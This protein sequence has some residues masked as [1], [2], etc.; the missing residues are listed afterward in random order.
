MTVLQVNPMLLKMAQS[1]VWGQAAQEKR[2]F[3][4]GPAMDPMAAGGAPP[5]P[6]GAPPMDPMAAGGMP[7]P[8]DPMAAGGMPPPMDPAAAGAA[9]MPPMGDP[10]AMGG[11]PPM[12]PMAAGAAGAAG[13]APKMKPEQMMQMIDFRMYNMQQQI[14][15]MLNALN[16]EIPP[17]ALVTPP[18]QMTPPPEAAMPGG[19]QD[20]SQQAGAEQGGGG[21]GSAISAIEPMQGAS[22]EMAAMGGGG[23]GGGAPKMASALPYQ[24]VRN[25]QY[26]IPEHAQFLK[27]A[28]AN[29]PAGWNVVLEKTADGIANTR[30]TDGNVEEQPGPKQSSPPQK[31]LNVAGA[32]GTRPG[33][34]AITAGGSKDPK[35]RTEAGDSLGPA[36]KAAAFGAALAGGEVGVPV[37][38]DT[39]EPQPGSDSPV[40][41]A[42]A[43]AAMFRSRTQYGD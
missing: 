27:E 15:A 10:M 29:A 6:G 3:Q 38:H 2:A 14:T 39:V 25:P 28:N 1:K 19:Q 24:F 36:N 18:G 32:P 37:P 23:G 26:A 21:G 33:T 8:M 34:Q 12:D 5:P 16:V 13:A 43:L 22:P 11:A 40:Q 35:S 17:G 41:G 42:A 4:P 20:P 9:G 7:P 31:S 30:S